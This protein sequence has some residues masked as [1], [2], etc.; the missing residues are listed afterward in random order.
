MVNI[1]DIN[2]DGEI[3][4]DVWGAIFDKQMDLAVK[5]KD[6]EGMGNLLDTTGT[7]IQTAN[8]QKWI[9]DFAWRV[10]EELSEAAECLDSGSDNFG[11]MEH[12]KEELIDGLHF[13][14]EMT[15]IAGYGAEIAKKIDMSSPIIVEGH[16]ETEDL[17]KIASWPVV[18]Q[19]GLMCNTLKNKPWKQT[20]MMTDKNEF[21]YRLNL[22]WENLVALLR[23]AGMDLDTI[24]IYYFK[25]NEV[26][27][28]RQRSKY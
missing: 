12:H 3:P 18:Y 24:Y 25:K 15:I 28:F 4:E 10:T 6:I 13:L 27:K 20:Q 2:F 9:K 14:V 26:N 11:N 1:S 21:E 23:F 7:N 17:L 19:L 22:A 5:Y 8:G 16:V